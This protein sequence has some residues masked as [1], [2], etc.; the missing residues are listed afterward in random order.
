MILFAYV[1]CISLTI[2]GKCDLKAR[3]SEKIMINKCIDYSLVI[4]EQV[5]KMSFGLETIDD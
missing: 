2:Q 5:R 4:R 1:G 3:S